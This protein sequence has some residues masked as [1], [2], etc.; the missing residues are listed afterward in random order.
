MG[1]YNTPDSSELLRIIA[2]MNRRLK[3]LE[4]GNRIGFTSVD[5]GSLIDNT[6]TTATAIAG[7]G[8]T[9][10]AVTATTTTTTAETYNSATYGNLA[11]VG[12][13]FSGT[14]GAGRRALVMISVNVHMVVN[15]ADTNF[16][17]MSFQLVG[18][19][20]TFDPSDFYAAGIK[21]TNSNA[22]A[23][24]VDLAVSKVVPLVS[25]PQGS[26]TITAKYSGGT[27]GGGAVSFNS[28]TLTVFPY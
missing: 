12:P 18:T 21:V 5:A 14:I 27:G 13:S 20:S 7:S 2:D 8:S 23:I 9:S 6:G 28:R 11:T 17:Y 26:Y 24:T 15:A 3:N 4:S 22:A 10:N 1:R 19:G 16:A 25:I